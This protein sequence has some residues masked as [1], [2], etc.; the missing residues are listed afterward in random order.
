MNQEQ[1]TETVPSTGSETPQPSAAPVWAQPVA[2]PSWKR[3]PPINQLLFA[4]SF[5]CLGLGAL[6]LVG[7]PVVDAARGAYHPFTIEGKRETC[8]SNLQAIARAASLYADDNEGRFPLIE[9]KQGKESIT[10]VTSLSPHASDSKPWACPLGATPS[11]GSSNYALNPVLAGGPASRAD[12][13]AATLLFGD[14]NTP[15]GLALQPPYPGWPRDN[16]TLT[17]AG[18]AFRHDG[19]A[20]VVYADGHTGTLDP[21]RVKE[22]AL[23]GGSAAARASLGRITARSAGSQALIAK[24]RTGDEAGAARLLRAKSSDVAMTS[25]DLL[26]L[27]ELNAQASPSQ[28]DDEAADTASQS[29]DALGWNLAWA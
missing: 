8:V 10:W 4:A 20:N 29:V 5:G 6:S 19:V 17:E 21:S 1:P 18:L 25:R 9:M 16:A 3:L 14:G 15:G 26:A 27:W 23:W 22:A 13:P 7:P 11:D 28:S 24:L 12:D 2:S